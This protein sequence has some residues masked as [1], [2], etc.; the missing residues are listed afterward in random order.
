[1]FRRSLVASASSS[2]LVLNAAARGRLLGLD[3]RA[4]I[5]VLEHAS[6]DRLTS[7]PR[8]DWAVIR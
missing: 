4:Q 5:V 7:T 8:E 1:M 2:F 3:K 6:Y